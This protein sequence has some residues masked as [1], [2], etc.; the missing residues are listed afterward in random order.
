MNT[1]LK[2][3]NIPVPPHLDEQLEDF[4]KHPKCTFKTKSEFIRDAVRKKLKEGEK[5]E[6][7]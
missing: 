6:V 4:L 2:R 3:W 1:D 5:H 7:C